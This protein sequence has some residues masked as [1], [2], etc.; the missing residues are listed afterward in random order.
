LPLRFLLDENVPSSVLR[1]LKKRGFNATKVTDL[2]RAGLRN[3]EVAELAA[4]EGMFVITL[5]SDFLR[6]RREMLERVKVIFIDVHPRDPALVARL[7]DTHMSNC[8]MSLERRNA[9]I[10]TREGVQA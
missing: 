10:L 5:D 4:K 3:S 1:L 6:L 9:V 8:I 2:R 7:V